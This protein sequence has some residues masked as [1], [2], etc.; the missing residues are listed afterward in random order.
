MGFLLEVC[1]DFSTNHLI[2]WVE[3]GQGNEVAAS[4]PPR[5]LG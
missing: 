2:Y 3:F 5:M 4:D 1:V